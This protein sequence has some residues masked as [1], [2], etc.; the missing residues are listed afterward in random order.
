MCKV[1]ISHD[2]EYATATAIVC[3]EGVTANEPLGEKY[4]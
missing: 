4:S 2:G 1:S 3:N